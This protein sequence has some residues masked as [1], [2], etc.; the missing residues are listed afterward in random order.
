MARG[1]QN[2]Q[3]LVE[4]LILF[5]A[6]AVFFSLLFTFTKTHQKNLKQHRFSSEGYLNVNAI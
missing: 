5:I 3:I 4:S 2:G 1:N 6:L